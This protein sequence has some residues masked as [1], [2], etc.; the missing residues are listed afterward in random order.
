MKKYLFIIFLL[1]NFYSFATSFC[2]KIAELS[3]NIDYI[4]DSVTSVVVITKRDIFTIKDP[5]VLAATEKVLRNRMG[6][7]RYY[8]YLHNLDPLD[9]LS[10]QG[11]SICLDNEPTITRNFQFPIADRVSNF[12]IYY[13]TFVEFNSRKDE[14]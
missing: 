3:T 12:V 2:G 14:I 8:G 6:D 11:Y 4:E 9:H 5:L 7:N 10:S 13:K 1:F